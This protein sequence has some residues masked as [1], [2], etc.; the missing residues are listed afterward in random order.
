MVQVFLLAAALCLTAEERPAITLGSDGAFRVGG[1]SALPPPVQLPDLFQVTAGAID[2]APQM[3]GTHSIEAGV[4]VFRPRFPL[5]PGVRYRAVYR[6]P[7]PVTAEFTIPKKD[8]APATSVTHVFPSG[9]RLPENL[10][11][12]YIHFSAPMSFGEAYRRL[13]LL[14]ERGQAIELPFLEIQEELWDRD[15][16]RLTVLF[17]PGRVKRGLTPHREVGP[18]LIAGRRYTL[19]IDRAWM[20]AEGIPLTSEF[21][22]SFEA[23][24]ADRTSPDTSAWR[25]TAP[26]A[27]TRAPLVVSFP[28]PLDHSLLGRLLTVEDVAGKAAIDREESRWLFTPEAPWKAGTHRLVAGE[29]L[30]DLAGNRLDKVF[31]VDVWEK[32]DRKISQRFRTLPFTVE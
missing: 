26:R 22:K 12:F 1:L 28:E 6:S 23:V 13:R 16:K 5:Q 8:T 21:R 14:D 10:L 3:L 2:D 25:V 9:A 20:D 27:G 31:D 30:E 18:P 19:V 4:V 29:W 7:S 15:R 24:E 17:D 32:V 11:K